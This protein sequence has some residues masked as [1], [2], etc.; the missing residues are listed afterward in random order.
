M[1]RKKLKTIIN[2][3][4]VKNYNI[5]IKTET[6]SAFLYCG[7]AS[8]DKIKNTDNEI[9][10]NYRN[11]IARYEKNGKD[12][13]GTKHKLAKYKSILERNVIDTYEGISID[14]SP[15]LIAVIRGSEFGKYWSI[16]ECKI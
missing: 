13:I 6:G 4:S 8:L 14:E 3:L 11:K 16:S 7:K 1:K 5:K 15:C 9:I 2:N 12:C 10:S